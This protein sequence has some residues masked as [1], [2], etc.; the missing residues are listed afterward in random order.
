MA[1]PAKQVQSLMEKLF[2][3]VNKDKATLPLVKACVFHYELEFI[4]PFEDG[5]GRMGRLWQQLLLM[6]A[7]PVFEY[8]PIESLIHQYQ[9]KYYQALEKSDAKGEST[10]FIEFSLEMI[11]KSLL[12]FSEEL[13]SSKPKSV[14]RIE[15]AIESFKGR[16]FSRK[17]YMI[18]HKEISTATASRDLVKAVEKGQLKIK[19]TKAKAVYIPTAK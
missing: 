14:D 18:L 17:D 8:L 5:N 1:P 3:F 9:K 16:S 4:H 13:V 7:S 11:L 15:L 6:K 2:L 19:G 10:D 12:E